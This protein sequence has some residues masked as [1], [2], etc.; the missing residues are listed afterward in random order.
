MSE[1]RTDSPN[2][3]SAIGLMERA[4]SA[5]L[6]DRFRTGFLVELP[7]EGELFV[8]GDL[9]GNQGN[10]YRIVELAGLQQH[11]ER[12]LILQELVH[13]LSGLEDVCRSHRLVETAAR[14]KVMFPARVH[15][16]LGNH[17]FAEILNLAIAKDG[18]ELNTSF[19]LG[20]Q[21][22]YGDRWGDVKNAY[23]HFWKSCPLAVR[24]ANG[25]LVCHSTPRLQKMGELDLDYLRKASSEQ[26]FRRNSPA[27]AMVWGRDYGAAAADEFARRMAA[28]VLIV[29]H[30]PCENGIA[31]PS[32][33]HIT[34]D[35]KDFGAR[36]L[37]LPLD[38]PLTQQDVLRHI[39]RLYP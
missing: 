9:H 8:T 3:D 25:L 28:E 6:S 21:E 26:V 30:T 11:P 36:Y 2:A 4:A 7:S 5:S 33:R 31:V 29:G 1:T 16:L 15:V 37:L 17:E 32:K 24:T 38:R 27:F 13:E 39:H 14:L 19:D 18:R 22:A 20:G 34:L 10:L 23:R 35:C 12:S